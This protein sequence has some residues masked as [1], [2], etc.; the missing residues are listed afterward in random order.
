MKRFEELT[1]WL[2]VRGFRY[3][4]LV[5]LYFLQKRLARDQIGNHLC[6]SHYRDLSNV[7]AERDS[8]IEACVEGW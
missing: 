4:F 2:T 6:P 8:R 7:E 5:D 1:S 3:N